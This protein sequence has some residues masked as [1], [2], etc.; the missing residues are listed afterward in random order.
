MYQNRVG[1]PTDKSRHTVY[2]SIRNILF[3]NSNDH[4]DVQFIFKIDNSFQKNKINNSR[5]KESPQDP[6]PTV[7]EEEQST[8]KLTS[9]LK[10]ENSPK[11]CLA[12]GLRFEDSSD[13]ESEE[14]YTRI[15]RRKIIK[16][17]SRTRKEEMQSKNSEL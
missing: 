2:D 11:V 4:D 13:D 8:E 7:G 9:I 10:H 17:R 5:S 12:K 6:V 15:T 3:D 14:T 16:T 1:G